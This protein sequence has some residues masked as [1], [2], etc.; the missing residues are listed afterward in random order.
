MPPRSDVGSIARRTQISI[1]FVGF[2]RKA[3]KKTD[4]A[5]SVFLYLL[6]LTIRLEYSPLMFPILHKNFTGDIQSLGALLLL[7]GSLAS[8]FY[9]FTCPQNGGT[10]PDI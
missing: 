1:R 2:N 5:E 6:L 3:A 4:F 9:A 10:I 7:L 8:P